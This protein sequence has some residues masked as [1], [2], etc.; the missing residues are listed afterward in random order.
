MIESVDVTQQQISCINAWKLQGKN[1]QKLEQIV[2]YSCNVNENIR[3][4]FN[5]HLPVLLAG[6]TGVCGPTIFAP[7]FSDLINS[8]RAQRKVSFCIS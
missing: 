5:I 7:R 6:P 4:Y 3:L 2:Y 1:H 8:A